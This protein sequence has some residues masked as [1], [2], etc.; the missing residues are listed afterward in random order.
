MDA[1]YAKVASVGL[2]V[3]YHFSQ[4]T[5]R[6]ENGRVVRRERLEHADRAS[7]RDRLSRWPRGVPMVMEASFGWA[8]LSDE[9]VSGGLQVDLSNCYKLEQMRKARGA[10]K[11]NAK[12]ADLLSLLAFERTDW[13]KVWRSPPAVRDRREWMR[14]R[15]G[16][17]AMGAATQARIRA[18][19]HRY[20]IF[21]EVGRLYGGEGRRFLGALCRDGRAEEVQLPDGALANLRGQVRLLEHLRQQQAE[22]ARRLHRALEQSPLVRR[23]DGVPGLGLILSHTIVAEI[24]QIERFRNHGALA[25]YS[26]LAPIAQDSG[27]AEPDKVPLGRHLGVRG[28]R[29][30]K[31]A[32]IEAA[33]GAVRKGGRWRAMFDRYTDAGTKHRNRGYIKVARALVKVVYAMWRDGTAYSANPPARPRRRRQDRQEGPRSGTGQLSQPMVVGR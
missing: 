5:M 11:T 33:R 20:G 31:W 25:A 32:F 6:D 18:I 19:F 17:V 12:D 30:L 14:Y 9:M 23:L 4:V 13:W 29:T 22:V 3:H 2:D 1:R 28:N 16:L 27:E 15:A 8:W 10:A 21:P 7:L 26:L 24:G